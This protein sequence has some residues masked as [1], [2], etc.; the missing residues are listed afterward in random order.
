MR[1][2]VLFAWPTRSGRTSPRRRSDFPASLFRFVLSR[3][4]PRD[5]ARGTLRRNAVI[6]TTRAHAGD[7]QQS[8]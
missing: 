5:L 1:A 8:R 4:R 6:P 7:R 3:G 2:N